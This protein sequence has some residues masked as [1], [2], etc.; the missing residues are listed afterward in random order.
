[1]PI[2]LDHVPPALYILVMP[3]LPTNETETP[4]EKALREVCASLTELNVSIEVEEQVYARHC[5]ENAIPTAGV[6][7]VRAELEGNLERLRRI[8]QN[9]PSTFRRLEISD[10]G[11][12]MTNWQEE[13]LL[14]MAAGGIR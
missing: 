9:L 4:D 5:L 8:R 1:M 13:Q 2:C 11:H 12:P 6:R 14:A 10:G 7:A 3:L